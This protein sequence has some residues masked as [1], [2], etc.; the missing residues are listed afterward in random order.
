MRL[1]FFGPPGAGKGTQAK[2]L[3]E[4]RGLIQLSTGDMLRAEIAANSDIGVN[5][6]SYMDK[7]ALV[8]DDVLVAMIEHRITQPDCKN[9]FI[10]DGFPRTI[11]QAEALDAMFEKH[12]TPL[13]AVV[14]F[15]VDENELFARVEKRA[16]DAR[17]AGQE[18]RADDNPETLKKRLG[19]Y[20]DQTY[21]VLG[22][23][24]GKGVVK[25]VNGM[26]PV[27]AVAADVDAALGKQ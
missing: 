13:D 24:K 23:Y 8:P 20:K 3:E 9:G 7:G 4:T 27:E 26:N 25:A 5:A 10:L 11:P 21:P 14:E 6:K 19:V 2:R 18:P 17:A 16:A 12:G 1:I 15:Q 22:Y